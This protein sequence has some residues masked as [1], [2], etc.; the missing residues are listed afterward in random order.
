MKSRLEKKLSEEFSREFEIDFFVKYHDE[1]SVSISDNR[2]TSIPC[3]HERK[4]IE[5]IRKIY[6]RILFD[7]LVLKYGDYTN[8]VFDEMKY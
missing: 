8:V 5:H 3:C 4:A 7:D 2:G 1:N 6:N